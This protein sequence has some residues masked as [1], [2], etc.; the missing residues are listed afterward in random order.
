MP[1]HLL[2]IRH[3]GLRHVSEA[4]VLSSL[5][6]PLRGLPRID[7]DVDTRPFAEQVARGDW[8]GQNHYL[9]EKA[10]EIQKNADAVENPEL[11][12]FGLAEIPHVLALGAYVGDERKV[13]LHDFDRDQEVWT[14]P[15]EGAGVELSTTDLPAGP[16]VTTRGIAVLRVC[17]SAEIADA[18]VRQ[19]VGDESLAD[20]TV[21]L[22]EKAAPGIGRVRSM[23][24]VQR[25]R[26]AVREALDTLRASRPSLETVHLF[27]AAPVSVCFAV[28]QE[29]RPR[30]SAPV[31]TYRYRKSEGESQ[32]TAALLISTAAD[33][34]SET[35]LTEE[36]LAVAA[37]V[38][39]GPWAKALEDVIQF[40]ALNEKQWGKDGSWFHHLEPRDALAEAHPFPELPPLSAVVPE[41]D[42]VDPNALGGDYGYD[43]DQG[44]WRLGDRLLVGLHRAV[45]GND[46]RLRELVR[47]FLFHEY[48]HDYHSLSKYTADEV[49]KFAN[50]LEHIDYTADTYAILHQLGWVHIHEPRKVETEAKTIA[51]LADQVELAIKSFWAFEPA[52]PVDE[53]QVRRVRRYLNW[54]WRHIQL[55]RCKDLATALKLFTQQPRIELSGID[56]VARRRRVYARLDRLDPTTHLELGLVLEDQRLYRVSESANASI[57]A[58][59]KAFRNADHKQILAFFRSVFEFA[60]QTGGELP[61]PAEPKKPRRKRNR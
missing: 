58:L 53:W 34:A 24:D 22:G 16:A 6:E 13:H 14:W 10:A 11:H 8:S 28:G 45:D 25:V 49:G 35:P 61:N 56:Q 59:L 23:E 3:S 27:I 19:V 21:R 41:R 31:Q 20:I 32:Y 30:N 26:T 36:E 12:Y 51:F 29:L 37:K 7:V 33:E 57:T 38:R 4:E 43:K 50:C 55:L 2:L 46:E 48:L 17:V 47:L 52:P 60:K 39:T 54:Y 1:T 9:R 18:D 5:P 44:I 42:R 40:A 15:A